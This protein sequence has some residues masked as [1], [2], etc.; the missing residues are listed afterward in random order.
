MK[1]KNKDKDRW[2]S[3]LRAPYERVFSK[4]SKRV[5]YRGVA[6]VQFQVGMNA[7]VFNFKRL[8][9]LDIQKVKL[10]LI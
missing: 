1:N 2:H 4:R 10:V 5:R 8:L 3:Q 9:S 7:L 6:K